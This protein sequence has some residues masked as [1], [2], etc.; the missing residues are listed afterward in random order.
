MACTLA[1]G[2]SAGILYLLTNTDKFSCSCPFHIKPDPLYCL[3]PAFFLYP[4]RA[5]AL[6]VVLWTKITTEN[7]QSISI[8][9]TYVYEGPISHRLLFPSLRHIF[10]KYIHMLYSYLLIGMGGFPVPGTFCNVSNYNNYKSVYYCICVFCSYVLCSLK[11]ATLCIQM[12]LFFN[13]LCLTWL[14]FINYAKAIIYGGH[15]KSRNRGYIGREGKLCDWVY[16]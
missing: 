8:H 7:H 6:V 16:E 1:A 10:R 12:L 13:K 2:W 14:Q 11:W 5:L 9:F 4:L 15:C 3:E